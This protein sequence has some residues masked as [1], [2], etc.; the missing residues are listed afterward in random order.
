MITYHRDPNTPGN[1]LAVNPDTLEG[2]AAVH[3]WPDSPVTWVLI[4]PAL[5]GEEIT[6]AEAR[7]LHPNLFTALDSSG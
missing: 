5:L 7:R 2:Y 1:V 6:E 4:D 3:P